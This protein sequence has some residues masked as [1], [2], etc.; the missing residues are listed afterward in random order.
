[1][2]TVIFK[3]KEINIEQFTPPLL[4]YI[5]NKGQKQNKYKILKFIQVH[6]FLNEAVISKTSHEQLK[7]LSK[8]KRQVALSCSTCPQISLIHKR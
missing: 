8:Y 6:K 7:W 2:L 4:N 1:M 5:T 3:L